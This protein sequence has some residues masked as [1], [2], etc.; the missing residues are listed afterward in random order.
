MCK[1]Y[2]DTM[3]KK[4]V[5]NEVGTGEGGEVT[6][7]KTIE[8][9][10]VSPD[11]FFK[12]YLDDLGAIIKC[13]NAEKNFILCCTFHKFIEYETNEIV[14]TKARRAIVGTCSEINERSVQNIFYRLIAKNIIIKHKDSF[15]LN[16]SLFFTGTEMAREKMFGLQMKYKIEEPKKKK[17]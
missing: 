7:T 8:R 16:P 9:S 4:L 12:T 17:K 10:I 11:K 5:Y 13:S 3:P 15:Y 1:N 14:L 2:I 6:Y